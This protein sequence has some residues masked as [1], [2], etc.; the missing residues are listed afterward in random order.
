MIETAVALES[1]KQI[2]EALGVIGKLVNEFI[3]ISGVA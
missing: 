2:D 1:I 3:K